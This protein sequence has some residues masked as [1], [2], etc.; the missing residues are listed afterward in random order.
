MGTYSTHKVEPRQL[1]PHLHIGKVSKSLET[2]SKGIILAEDE[3]C[4]DSCPDAGGSFW[5]LSS[6]AMT[7]IHMQTSVRP[8]HIVHKEDS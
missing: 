3:S 8:T 2:V 4:H 7:A 1:F 6:V 5:S